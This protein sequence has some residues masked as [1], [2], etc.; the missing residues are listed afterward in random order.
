VAPHIE[1]KSGRIPAN[2]LKRLDPLSPPAAQT[3]QLQPSAYSRP[4]FHFTEVVS[5][6]PVGAKAASTQSATRSLALLHASAIT[7]GSE[8]PVVL[9]IMLAE[10]N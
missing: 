7:L 5:K 3:V 6:Y 1:Q 4:L 10:E 2:P 8:D 9:E